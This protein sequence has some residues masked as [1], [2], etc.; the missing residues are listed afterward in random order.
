LAHRPD[1]LDSIARLVAELARDPDGAALLPE[2][3]EE[4][5]Q[6]IWDAREERRTWRS[7]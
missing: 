4:I 2:G 5:W 3:F 1:R 6:A 7:G